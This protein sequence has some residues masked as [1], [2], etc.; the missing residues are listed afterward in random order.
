[1]R[2]RGIPKEKFLLGGLAVI[3][4]F[5]IVFYIVYCTRAFFSS[6]MAS[7]L[8]LASEQISKK[9]FFPENFC[10]STGIF[11]FTAELFV[12]PLM[13][14]ISDWLLCR[15]LAVILVNI[16]S[17]FVMFLF[18]RNMKNEKGIPLI[19]LITVV[20]WSMPTGHYEETVY[21]AAYLPNIIFEM[22]ILMTIYKI[23]SDRCKKHYYYILFLFV[24]ISNIEGI[25]NLAVMV[26]PLVAAIVVYLFIENKDN[27]DKYF[28]HKKYNYV[29]LIIICAS[30]FAT[31]TFFLLS[32]KVGLLSGSGSII[33]GSAAQVSEN[34]KNIIIGILQYYNAIGEGGIFSVKGISSCL[35]L[36]F[37][38][39]SSILIPLVLLINIQ[40][41][42]NKYLKIYILYSWI[43]NLLVIYMMVF[44]TPYVN[45]Y[46]Y[47]V[48]W[49]NL[50]LT[51]FFICYL[52]EHS[53]KFIVSL[54]VV[55]V[56]SVFLMGHGSYMINTVNSIKNGYEKDK[57]EGTIVEYLEDNNLTYGF[58]SYWNAYKN[59]VFS[60]GK[61]KIVSWCSYPNE[62][63]YWL[64]SREWYNPEV[65]SGTC[66]ILLDDTEKISDEY[67]KL[68][69]DIRYFKN[70]TVLVYDKHIYL[71]DKLNL[72][73][74]S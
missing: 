65:Y 8:L 71:Y 67:Y 23:L 58:A 44:T 24:F 15:E 50:V 11:I 72:R 38:I 41:V 43:S 46:Y 7:Y 13:N 53:H 12:V 64:T 40:K 29:I 14:F 45:R 36:L 1:M 28:S 34:F 51:V 19:F 6:D 16:I 60:D 68:A 5:C 32:K 62:P 63:Y 22:C 2:N 25:R 37:L 59:M 47:T 21:E 61:I 10:Y 57:E 55:S 52:I 17:F 4:F 33:F 26:I 27:L 42:E 3:S 35:N 48:F 66:F 70:Y 74:E 56:A 18:F 39:L 9:E 54:V 49:H 69:S 73:H 20:L 30:L 31:I